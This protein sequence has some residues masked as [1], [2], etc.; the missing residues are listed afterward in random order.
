[1]IVFATLVHGINVDWGTNHG[2]IIPPT[3]TI[4]PEPKLPY[5]DPAPVWEN[6]IDD[7]PNPNPYRY[8]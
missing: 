7:I 5:R 4:A 6:S 1:M 2:P 3:S 8:N